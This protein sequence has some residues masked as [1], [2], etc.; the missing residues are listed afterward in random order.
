MYRIADKR[1]LA[2]GVVEMVVEAPRVAKAHKPG[3]FLIVMNREESERIPLTIADSDKEKGTVTIVFLQVG[4]STIELGDEFDAGDSLFAVLGPLGTP[5]HIENYGTVAVVGGGLGV[6]PIHPICKG[7]K[8]AGNRVIALV[9]Y[10]S[11]ELMFWTDR[12]REASTETIVTTDDGTYG[13][14][15]F[16]TQALERVH[17]ETALDRVFAIGPPIMMRVVSDMTKPWGIPTVVSLNTIMV[18]GTGMCGGC[19]V[20]VGSET[21]FVCVDGPDFDAHK[22]DWDEMFQRMKTYVDDERRAVDRNHKCKLRLA[23]IQGG[24]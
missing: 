20:G 23:E 1:V 7:L 22:V 8:E 16:V 17:E 13:E 3:Q 9:G 10:R 18:D 11:K 24:R 6:A 21:K 19:R 4:K 5:T 14:K 15:G 12:I 2:R